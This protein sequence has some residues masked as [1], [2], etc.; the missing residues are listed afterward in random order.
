MH[1]GQQ[2][3]LAGKAEVRAC[4]V[5]RRVVRAE[6]RHAERHEGAIIREGAAPQALDLTPRMRDFGEVRLP[7][8]GVRFRRSVQKYRAD[9]GC[10]QAL[11]GGIRVRRRRIV[12][13]PVDER[14]RSAVDL[15][16]RAD[17]RGNADILGLEAFREAGVHAR[18]VLK[19]RPVRRDA[20]QARL[21]RV[22]VRIDQAGN[23][24]AA[25]EIER[26]FGRRVDHRS[27]LH[28][29]MAIDEDIAHERADEWL[30]RNDCC[31]SEENAFRHV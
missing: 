13:A 20:A 18:E 7:G 21:P 16:Y 4:D 27:D 12:V 10:Q 30:H 26:L 29:A 22:H 5:E 19:Q 28:D 24:D 2:A 23:D 25:L 11:D 14:R 15:V 17:Q 31:A 6:D 1:R 9:A 3:V 8:L